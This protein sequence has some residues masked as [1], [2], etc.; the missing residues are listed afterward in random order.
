MYKVLIVHGSPRMEQSNT[1]AMI[2]PLIE[3]MKKA[4]AAVELIYTKKKKILSCTGCFSCW[5]E[6]VC[7]TFE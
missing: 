6:D 2:T 5:Y 3:G 7:D 1:Y 4:G